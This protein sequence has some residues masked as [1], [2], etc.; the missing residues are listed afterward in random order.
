MRFGLENTLSTLAMI[1]HTFDV[2]VYTFVEH[3]N[4]KTPHTGHSIVD[5]STLVALNR[6]V[7]TE[8]IPTTPV[9]AY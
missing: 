4:M 5:L 2:V 3:N 1:L 7:E 9:D 8:N 6:T